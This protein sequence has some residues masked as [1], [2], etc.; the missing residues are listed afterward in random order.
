ME[1]YILAE[2][3]SP[4]IVTLRNKSTFTLIS[5]RQT[6][7]NTIN[8]PSDIISAQTERTKYNKNRESNYTEKCYYRSG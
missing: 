4:Y 8:Q 7:A 3:E 2:R 1:A 5:T 6:F